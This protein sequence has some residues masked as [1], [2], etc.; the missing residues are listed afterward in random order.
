M[1]NKFLLMAFLVLTIC[2]QGFAARDFADFDVVSEINNFNKSVAK[3]SP[4]LFAEKMAAMSA[5]LFSFFRGTAHIMNLDL[6]KADKLE[7]LRSAPAGLVAGDLHMHNFSIVK[8]D[9]QPPLYAID[10]LDEAYADAPLA[11]D[12]FRLSV[13]LLAGFSKQLSEK[14]QKQVLRQLYA[15]Y[16]ARAEDPKVYD[17]PKIPRAAFMKKFIAEET[18]VK[19]SKFIKK[20]TTQQTPNSFSAEKF[21]P[22]P[23]KEAKVAQTALQACLGGIPRLPA[24][25]ADILDIAQRFDKGLSSIGLKR[26]FV[27]LQ[28]G[29]KSWEDNLIIEVKEMRT[30]SVGTCN[31]AKQQHTTIEALRRA[32]QGYDPFLGTVQIAGKS[33]LM[34]QSYPWSQTI[35]NSMISEKEKIFGLVYTLGFITADF[36]AP[37]GKGPKMK[38]WL[39]KSGESIIPLVFAYFEQ[40]KADYKSLTDKTK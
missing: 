24:G 9:V 30:S 19:W 26:Y 22:V 15:G 12:I 39:E 17:W 34:R 5:D 21:S 23:E 7:L 16:C 27:L 20:R 6:K 14:E 25:Y 8:S 36:H 38:A 13:S 32:H 1:K 4:K 35:E 18:D 40:L 3:A 2:S 11:F 10:D 29:S 31:I 28:G 33:Y 37:S